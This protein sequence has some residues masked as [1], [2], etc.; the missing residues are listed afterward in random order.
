MIVALLT[1]IIATLIAINVPVIVVSAIGGWGNAIS[2]S[3]YILRVAMII[4]PIFKF[5]ALMQLLRFV[6]RNY[7]AAIA[8]G[9]IVVFFEMM[10]TGFLDLPDWINNVL[11]ST[12]FNKLLGYVSNV[13]EQTGAISYISKISNSD[14]TIVISVNLIMGLLFMIGGYI[15]C[16]KNDL[17]T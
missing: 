2:L 4:L 15:Y 7:F 9:F 6:M 16:K 1:A 3:S 10:I 17:D 8:V 14:L 5:I 11:I 12:S 13:N